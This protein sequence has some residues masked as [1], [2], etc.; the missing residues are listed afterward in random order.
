MLVP[1]RRLRLQRD[2]QHTWLHNEVDELAQ[3]CSCL[4]PNTAF[5][6]AWL[7]CAPKTLCMQ[8]LLNAGPR[9]S[10]CHCFSY[11]L[12][13]AETVTC[14]GKHWCFST[15]KTIAETMPQSLICM[16]THKDS[17]KSSRSKVFW[18]LLSCGCCFMPFI[19]FSWSSCC[20]G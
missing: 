16:L 2:V 19:L 13:S 20:V 8:L 17:Q 1:S 7:K 10:A 12:T 14:T 6:S 18:L 5:A 11:G 9:Q 15:T 3:V 4:L